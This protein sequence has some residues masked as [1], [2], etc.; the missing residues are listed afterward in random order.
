VASAT[1]RRPAG[2]DEPGS[3]GAV[4]RAARSLSG[5]STAL[6]LLRGPASLRELLDRAPAELCRHCGFD[7]AAVFR[8]EGTAMVL[9]SMHSEGTDGSFDALVPA[10]PYEPRVE[11]FGAA[12]YVGAPIMP[13]G[14]VIGFIR[15]DRHRSGAAVDEVDRDAIAAFAEGLG[16]AAERAVL[17]ERMAV[18]RRKIDALQRST[19]SDVE[20][21]GGGHVSTAVATLPTE[22]RIDALL[23]PREGEVLA[24]MAEGSTNRAIATAL[25]ICEGTVK[26]HVKSI[27]RK[28]RAANR[29]EAV[30]RFVRNGSGLQGPS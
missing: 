29:A 23:T 2:L 18:Q 11:G 25:G 16:F 21:D 27:L 28:L 15:A 19:D 22:V 30:S 14:R 13:S 5:V 9:A 17:H 4:F 3:F 26:S 8:L 12:S 20:L 24:L 7:R 1:S 6:R 10:G